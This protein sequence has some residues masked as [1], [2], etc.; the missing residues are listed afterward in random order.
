MIGIGLAGL[1]S[2]NI[3]YTA[4]QI[5]VPGAVLL[6]H[7]LNVIG[8][9]RLLKLSPRHEIPHLT[10]T[11]L[12]IRQT[13]QS[14]VPL[15]NAYTRIHRFCLGNRDSLNSRESVMPVVDRYTERRNEAVFLFKTTRKENTLGFWV[16]WTAVSQHKKRLLS[17]CNW[18]AILDKN[19][20]SSA[21]ISTAKGY[22]FLWGSSRNYLYR[23]KWFIAV[24]LITFSIVHLHFKR[25]SFWCLNEI[26]M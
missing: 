4:K 22:E 23:N 7:V 20:I 18:D 11:I 10:F 24:L 3:F 12:S 2:L 26:P 9:Q 16:N 21:T 5:H 17:V 14:T 6:D 15:R 25:M 8:L 13:W 1:P 19:R